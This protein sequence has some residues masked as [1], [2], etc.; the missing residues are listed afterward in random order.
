MRGG[1]RGSNHTERLR[2]PLDAITRILDGSNLGDGTRRSPS[3]S[4]KSFQAWGI[5][6]GNYDSLAFVTWIDLML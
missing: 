4:G 6:W 1:R 5:K 2:L 3:L